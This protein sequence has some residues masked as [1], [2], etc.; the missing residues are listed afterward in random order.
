MTRAISV[1]NAQFP[2]PTLRVT[3]IYVAAMFLSQM[4]GT[5]TRAIL[6]WTN[7]VFSNDRICQK[8]TNFQTLMC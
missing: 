1:M 6:Q 5:L 2:K 7:A 4:A 8:A 3:P